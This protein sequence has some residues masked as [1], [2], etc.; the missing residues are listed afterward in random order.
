[1]RLFSVYLIV[2][3]L[4]LGG[5]MYYD[6]LWEKY[7]VAAQID[8]QLNECPKIIED[9]DNKVEEYQKENPEVTGIWGCTRNCYENFDEGEYR[10]ELKR[11]HSSGYWIPVILFILFTLLLFFLY[12]KTRDNHNRI[13]KIFLA[14]LL[15]LLISMGY[16][17]ILMLES[18]NTFLA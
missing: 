15:I 11:N 13:S 2:L 4:L 6:Y 18:M 3:F 5:L 9:C 7:Y 10:A 12:V 14:G 16:V 1:M 17:L 8:W